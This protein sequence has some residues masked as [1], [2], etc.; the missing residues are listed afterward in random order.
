MVYSRAQFDAGE[1]A[2]LRGEFDARAEGK[3]RLGAGAAYE[4]VKGLRGFEEV[5]QK[6]YDYVLEEVGFASRKELDFDEFVE[7]GSYSIVFAAASVELT[8]PVSDL[9][10]TQGGALRPLAATEGEQ[11][12]EVTDPSREER[13]RGLIPTPCPTCHM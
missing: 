8:M 4:L 11:D 10:R 12:R 7:V 9:W 13:W 2:A 5:K 6:D 1:I 3:E